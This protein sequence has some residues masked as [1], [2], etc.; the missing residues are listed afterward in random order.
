MKRTLLILASVAMTA[1]A[2]FAGG[3]L[4]AKK[5]QGGKSYADE[6][7]S[8][9]LVFG[10][11]D[12][13]DGGLGVRAPGEMKGAI[14][15][16]AATSKFWV[17]NEIKQIRIG[18]GT[19]QEKNPQIQVFIS[20]S[21]Q[22]APVYTQTATVST[23]G[24]NTIDLTTPYA[25][26]QAEDLV[27]GYSYTCTTDNDFPIGIDNKPT[28]VS[29]GDNIYYVSNGQRIWDHTGSSGSISIQVVLEGNSLPQN[30][31][32]ISDIEM[33]FSVVPGA[34]F[35]SWAT[36]VNQGAQPVTSVGIDLTV[37]G[38]KIENAT[39]VLS[40]SNIPTGGSG[41]IA[42][43][44]LSTSHEISD[45]PV[46]VTVTQV[47]NAPNENDETN[48]ITGTTA[49]FTTGVD[50]MMV[51]EEWTGT[52]CG[53]CPRGIV[54]M[55]YMDQTYGND[56]FIGI[57]VHQGD[58][59]ENSQFT[60]FINKYCGVG[61]PN[62]IVNRE[63][64]NVM[65]PNKTTLRSFYTKNENAMSFGEVTAIRA[66]YDQ[67]AKKLG[68]SADVNFTIPVV[69][70]D[71]RVVFE[72][73]EDNVGP[74][75]QTNYYSPG[76][77]TGEKLEGW[78]DKNPSVPTLFQMVARATNGLNGVKGSIPANVE[79][80]TPVSYYTSLNTRF[81]KD[82]NNCKIIALLINGRTGVIVNAKQAYYGWET[83]VEGVEADASDVTISAAPG[84]IIIDGEYADCSV[85]GID[86][87]SVARS[88]A[89]DI[90]V[91]PG[92]YIVKVTGLDGRLVVKKIKI[93][94]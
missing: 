46:K 33:P 53:W 94:N 91:A 89:G 12:G 82:I 72:V 59:M 77:G 9:Q 25:V 5:S 28:T 84:K 54:G 40:P 66:E 41:T 79:P 50:R 45:V 70:G 20:H 7:A 62:C 10:Y 31:V 61:F 58:V 49:C 34:R 35:N 37:D 57:A 3:P 75:S 29:L 8:T 92:T 22:G 52:W 86:G 2:A 60:D 83:G 11:C 76:Y 26:T 43:T 47:N 38:Q 21:L 15:V 36:I 55:E 85:Y 67:N 78:D 39:Y 64:N 24:W 65:D 68:I 13:Y 32:E 63:P 80:N 44:R 27:F 19:V 71:Y 56:K 17:G 81:I 69:D 1:S 14:I 90:S 51:V 73:A 4:Q 18:F 16:P 48:S 74:Y 88:A 93:K 87:K 23:D 42:I 6:L 30:C